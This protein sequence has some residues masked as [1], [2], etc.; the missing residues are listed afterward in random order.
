[1]KVRLRS[2]IQSEHSQS[3]S[4]QRVRLIKNIAHYKLLF[5]ILFKKKN[6]NL[7]SKQ[8]AGC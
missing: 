7:A 4:V 5:G 6:L 2:G 8:R 1:M 3:G